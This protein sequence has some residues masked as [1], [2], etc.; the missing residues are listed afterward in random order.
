MSEASF[1]RISHSVSFVRSSTLRS[2]LHLSCVHQAWL[3][4]RKCAFVKMTFRMDSDLFVIYICIGAVE[5]GNFSSFCIVNRKIEKSLI[6]LS[7]RCVCIYNVH[8]RENRWICL[9][10][11]TRERDTVKSITIR[12]SSHKDERVSQRGCS[13]DVR[14]RDYAWSFS[15]F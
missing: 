10:Q 8:T 13:L 2:E 15:A 11:I 1:K 9:I 3:A 14:K 6:I 4:S 5:T 12:L 7:L